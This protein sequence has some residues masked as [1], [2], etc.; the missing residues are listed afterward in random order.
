MII[1]YNNGPNIGHKK[2]RPA[3]PKKN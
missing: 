1:F 2:S 3:I